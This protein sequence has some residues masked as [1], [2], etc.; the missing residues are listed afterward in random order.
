[1][2]ETSGFA[3]SHVSVGA[4]A[5][6]AHPRCSDRSSAFGAECAFGA[7]FIYVAYGLSLVRNSHRGWAPTALFTHEVA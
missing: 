3:A 5:V 7:W 4:K 1:M 6:G 2:H